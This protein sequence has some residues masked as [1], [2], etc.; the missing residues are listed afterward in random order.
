MTLQ[1]KK[2]HIIGICGM[3]MS[4]IAQYLKQEGW[5]VQGSDQ[6]SGNKTSAQLRSK[7]IAVF[8]KAASNITKDISYIARSTAVKDNDPEI[9][10]AKKLQIP[11]FSRSHVL[12]EITKKHSQVISVSGA[13]GKTTTTTMAAELFNYL[14]ADH[15]V[16]AGGIMHFCDNN[17]LAGRKDLMIVEADESDGTFLKLKTDVAVITNIEFEHAEYY[18]NFLHLLESYEQFVNADNV[19]QVIVC[20]DDWGIKQMK[21]NK[22][23]IRYGFG[24]SNDIYAKDIKDDFTIVIGQ[25]EIRNVVLKA[26]GEHNILNA[27]CAVAIAVSQYGLTS[28]VIEGARQMMVAFQGVERRFNVLPNKKNIT[29]IDDY[30]HHPSEI[31]STIAAARQMNSRII[32]VLQP[33]R[34]TRLNALMQDFVTCVDGADTVIISD[35]FAASEMPLSGIHATKLHRLICERI[36]RNEHLQLKKSYFCAGREEIFECLDLIMLQNDLVLFMGAGTVSSWAREYAN[37]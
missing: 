15:T 13:H 31:R 9:V 23:T 32:A 28:A 14:Y 11:I 5:D 10:M 35:V 6:S 17:L 12:S 22:P 27:L 21:I 16:F 30:A 24:E 37:R 33:H 29:I 3:G 25:D 19:K 36:K 18:E 26:R 2:I 7:N 4:A 34:Y 20:G 8:P 1:N